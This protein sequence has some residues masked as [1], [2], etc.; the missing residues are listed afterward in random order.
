M[1]PRFDQLIALRSK[2]LWVALHDFTATIIALIA[3]IA[4]RG[5]PPLPSASP[6]EA[7]LALALFAGF[8]MLVYQSCALYASRWRFA[9]LYD[10]FGLCQAVT[11]LTATLMLLDYAVSP[12]VNDGA[13]LL[14]ERT[15]I[16]YW[17][18]QLIL[19]G[20]P[21]V[22]YRGYRSWQRQRAQGPDPLTAIVIGRATDAEAVIRAVEAGLAGPIR[23][24]G[25]VSSEPN[26]THQAVRGVSIWGSTDKLEALVQAAGER[27]VTIQRAI[28][29]ADIMRS[30][31]L[32]ETVVGTLRRLSIATIRLDIARP[33]GPTPRRNLHNVL[34]D[35]LLLRPL[36]EV[37]EAPLRQYVVGKRVLITG[38]GGSIGAELVI[39]SAELGASS[40]LVI[41]HSEAALHAILERA[42]IKGSPVAD[43][44]FGRLCDIRDRKRLMSLMADFAPD[45][46]FHAAALKHVPHLE[47]EVCDAVRTNVLGTVNAADAAFASG[48][49][50]FVL[51]ST[52][53]AT[54]PVSILGATK[55]VA[56]MYIQ[57][58]DKKLKRQEGRGAPRL[59]SVRF[60]NVLGTAGS[61]VPRFRQQIEAGGPITVTDPGMV[62]YFMTKREAT[63][64]LWSAA[65]IASDDTAK[66]R[67]SVLVLNMGQPVRIDDLAKRMIRLAGY[68]PGRDI[69]IVYSGKRPGERLSETLFEDRE[70]TMDVGIEG[71]VAAEAQ[72]PDWATLTQVISVLAKVCENGDDDKAREIIGELVDELQV[73][74]RIIPM[75]PN[76]PKH[77]KSGRVGRSASLGATVQ[78]CP[79]RAV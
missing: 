11:I 42:D 23:L 1:P 36:T 65:R 72:A 76:K 55:R 14:G 38:G 6:A 52:D 71:I 12:R 16:I 69:A 45:I 61:V 67:P 5:H 66:G 9:S 37:D 28:L 34:D 22:A 78:P 59:V 30:T 79:Y 27:G 17:C 4:L 47:R 50:T 10:L 53:K 63:D 75:R 25:I 40:V 64:L 57:A 56:E 73:P 51:I 32:S 62:R 33:D 46:V 3:A 70:L 35:D 44:I 8:A 39:R 13:K 54:L 21:R 43:R 60:G 7:I 49:D 24:I 29:A 74:A 58:L 26:E 15:L 77:I 20:G 31:A 48:A 68:E 41:D 18:V 2:L 19:L